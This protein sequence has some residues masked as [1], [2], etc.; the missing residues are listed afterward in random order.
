MAERISVAIKLKNVKYGTKNMEILKE[1]TGEIYKGGI[2][3]LVG[4][5]GSGKSTLFSLLNGMKTPQTGTIIINDKDIGQ[6][7][8]IQLRREVGIVLQKATMLSGDV[9]KNL[10]LPY[11][12]QG[13][14][15]SEE[16]AIEMLKLIGL[17]ESFLH[18]KANDLSGGQQQRISIARTLLNEPPILLLDEITSSLDQA[19]QHEIE[20][21]ISNVNKQ[22]STTI[23]WITHNLR[24]ALTIGHDTWV[25]IDGKLVESGS[26][27]LLQNPR[28]DEVRR[29]LK[30]GEK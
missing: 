26:S 1:I 29:F 13:K 7:D 15:L 16:K 3:T 6:Y 4:P 11:T 21:L 23:L 28:T 27:D 14:R 24:Q 17:N 8:P 18:R 10:S 20:Q 22:F 2:T 25:M 9:Y 19:S 12:L 5:S 30:G